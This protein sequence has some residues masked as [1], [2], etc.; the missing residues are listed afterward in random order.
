[1]IKVLLADDQSLV[2][3]GFLRVTRR[4]PPDG[5]EEVLLYFREGDL[6]AFNGYF[7]SGIARSVAAGLPPMCASFSSKD[8]ATEPG[9]CL[10]DTERTGFF[11]V[12]GI[13][14]PLTGCVAAHGST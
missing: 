8:C 14:S 7:A 1:M 5:A 13:V 2:R 11:I 4:A 6:T 3:A 9:T 12:A 10:D